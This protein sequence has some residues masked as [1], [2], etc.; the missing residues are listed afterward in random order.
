MIGEEPE[1]GKH[2]Q[3]IKNE[4]RHFDPSNLKKKLCTAGDQQKKQYIHKM[5]K[6]EHFCVLSSIS[7]VVH[8]DRSSLLMKKKNIF[9]TYFL[10]F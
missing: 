9:N 4:E 10:Y 6:V 7:C 8:F 1:V 5:L 3:T 2:Y